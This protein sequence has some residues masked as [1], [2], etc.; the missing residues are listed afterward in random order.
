M[1]GFQARPSVDNTC[2]PSGIGT[3]ASVAKVRMR[4][5]LH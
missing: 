3:F 5:K 1:D 2:L 4:F